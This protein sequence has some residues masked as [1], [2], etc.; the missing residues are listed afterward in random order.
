MPAATPRLVMDCLLLLS[1]GRRAARGAG[2]C[3]RLVERTGWTTRIETLCACCELR[4][5]MRPCGT[6]ARGLLC[7]S[8]YTGDEDGVKREVGAHT[9][10]RRIQAEATS[11]NATTPRIASRIR[12]PRAHSSPRMTSFIVGE[13]EVLEW[14]LDFSCTLPGGRLSSKRTN[15]K[16]WR[17]IDGA[18][19]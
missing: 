3:P 4:G 2:R 10:R 14:W 13:A 12:L 16:E 5:G 8:E 15:K 19:L 9:R 1:A 11:D 17:V 7:R 18:A 6:C